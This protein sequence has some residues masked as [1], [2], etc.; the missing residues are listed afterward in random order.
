MK[1]RTLK[2]LVTAITIGLLF[3]ATA[4]FGADGS[5]YFD[6]SMSP[7]QVSYT[8][9]LSKT[10]TTGYVIVEQTPL[11]TVMVYQVVDS[12][13]QAKSYDKTISGPNTENVSYYYDAYG[14]CTVTRGDY[15]SLRV[16]NNPADNMGCVR[17]AEGRWTP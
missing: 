15:L 5:P 11:D 10:S 12:L 3:S 13:Y 16:Y 8:D 1:K 9:F 17:P 4:I 2:N 6:F 14:Q 7:S